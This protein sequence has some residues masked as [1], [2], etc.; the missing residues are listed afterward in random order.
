MECHKWFS[1]FLYPCLFLKVEFIASTFLLFPPPGTLD[2]NYDSIRQ[3][4]SLPK[5]ETFFIKQDC[6]VSYKIAKGAFSSKKINSLFTDR[7]ISYNLRNPLPH[8]QRLLRRNYLIG[9]STNQ[10]QRRWN[11]LP[12]RLRD[13]P[14]LPSFKSNISKFVT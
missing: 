14:F 10:L 3:L 8:S 6:I 2:H 7:D 1:K 11:N 4:L 13:S 5:L 12:R 9:S